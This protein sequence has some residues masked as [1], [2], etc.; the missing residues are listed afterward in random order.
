M[1][2]DPTDDDMPPWMAEVRR[3]HRSSPDAG[4][5]WP[6]EAWDMLTNEDQIAELARGAGPSAGPGATTGEQGTAVPDPM[7]EVD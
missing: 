2:E 5:T 3:E 6:I 4:G 7:E 1:E